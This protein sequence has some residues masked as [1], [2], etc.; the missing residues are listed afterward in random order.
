MLRSL[1]FIYV[2]IV[3]AC[4]GFCIGLVVSFVLSE[5]FYRVFGLGLGA[6]LGVILL[7]TP[8]LGCM[9]LALKAF[10]ARTKAA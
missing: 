6:E 2:A 4:A 10:A 1:Q 3:S 9:Y 8:T 5:F 7:G